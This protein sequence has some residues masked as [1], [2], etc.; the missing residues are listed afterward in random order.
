MK[1]IGTTQI[2]IMI[3]NIFGKFF[4]PSVVVVG[5]IFLVAGV[6]FILENT[7][8]G[9][10]LAVIGTFGAF[11]KTGVQIDPAKQLFREHTA[12][13]S[14]KFGNWQS[15][16]GYTDVAVLKKSISTRAYS[17]SNRSATTSSEKYLDVCLLDK[18]HRKKQTISR[19]TDK[20]MAIADAKKLT[21]RLTLNY[22]RYN[23]EIS[24]ESRA[25]RR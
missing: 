20:E 8:I 19:W 6:L 10:G 24:T 1:T 17:R 11:A 25:K 9:I 12:L 22:S 2:K 21:E 3:D 18:S 5:Y 4:P 13:F 14:L 23:P 7:F 16:E 15:L